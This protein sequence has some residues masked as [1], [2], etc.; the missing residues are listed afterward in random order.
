MQVEKI[1]KNI[2]HADQNKAVQGRFFSQT[3]KRAGPIPTH[4]Q[5]GMN[6]Q[7]FFFTKLI[8]VQ[9][10]IRPCRGDYFLKINKRA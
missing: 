6:V 7:G 10:K 3:N 5:D 2:K 4:V 9:T 8:N 1:L